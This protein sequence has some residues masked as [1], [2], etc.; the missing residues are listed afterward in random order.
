MTPIVVTNNSPAGRVNRVALPP[1]GA[2]ASISVSA[3]VTAVN[4]ARGLT[5]PITY[6]LSR[7]NYTGTVMPAVTGLPAGVTGTW[8]DSSLTGADTTTVLTLTAAADAGLVTDDAFV[9]T[10]SGTGVTDATV[11]STVTVVV[12]PTNN[13]PVGY[14]QIYSNPMSTIPPLGSSDAY[15]FQRFEYNG[16][17]LSIA[18]NGSG[19]ESDPNYMRCLFPTGQAGGDNYATAFVAG[20]GFES[21]G[22]KRE[23]YA[24]VRFKLDASW[25]DNGNT[26]TKFF[27]FDQT[28]TAGINPKN[29]HYVNLTFLGALTPKFGIQRN[30]WTYAGT[31]SYNIPSGAGAPGSLAKGVWHTLEMQAIAN[32]I[33]PNV[34]ET[35]NGVIRMWINGSLW[36]EDTA[37]CFFY[38]TQTV[39]WKNL[40]FNPT[41][42]GG[43]NPVPANQYL[44]LDHMYVSVKT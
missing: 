26:G 31:D 13:E 39:G 14:T 36:I 32:T 20:S 29:N 19:N 33:V 10:F 28:D 11:N 27:F 38:R 16:N 24:R 35:N 6:T 12:A 3:N 1:V 9:V 15:G 40:W 30:G 8:S 23:L 5:T 42:G 4:V 17:R 25:T 44:D 7:T 41:Y 21:G 2:A 43:T 37:V 18:T 22:A 34:S